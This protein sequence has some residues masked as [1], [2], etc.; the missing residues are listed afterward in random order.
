M[1]A[2]A[3][4]LTGPRSLQ[5]RQMIIPDVGDRGA[6]L[7]VEACGLCGTDHE[8]FTGHL[9]AGF[10]FVPG[11]EIVGI[12]EHVGAAAGQRWGVQAGQR[13]AVEVFRSCRDCPECRRGEYRRCAVNGIATMFGFVDVEIGAGLWGGYAT[14]VE[15]PW[16]AMLLPIAEDMDP[17]LATLFNPLGAGIQW[18]RL[19]PTPEPGTS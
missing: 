13:V 8:Q 16:D 5:R 14:H 3:M 12:V 11:H 4:V 9:P 6:I 10:S 15:L 1:I 7:R 19:F 18:G 17:V 2:E